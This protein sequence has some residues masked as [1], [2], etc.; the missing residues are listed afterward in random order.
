MEKIIFFAIFF[1]T[2]KAVPQEQPLMFNDKNTSTIYLH[3]YLNDTSTKYFLIFQSLESFN[4][5]RVLSVIGS[6][7]TEILNFDS[8]LFR[9]KL[10]SFSINK[11]LELEVITPN[12]DGKY[13]IEKHQF[14]DITKNGLVVFEYENKQLLNKD[15]A[16]DNDLIST[17][18]RLKF[19]DLNNDGKFDIKLKTIRAYRKERN[20][21][22]D[23]RERFEITKKAI[24]L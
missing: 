11:S 16:E 2:L 7:T 3:D 10:Y 17:T 24:L 9:P 15:S 23:S 22:C 12:I 14:Y 6:D 18:H 13:I 8:I 20:C 21:S 1:I 5:I 4:S 19:K